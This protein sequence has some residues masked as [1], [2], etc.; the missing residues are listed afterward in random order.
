MGNER[1]YLAGFEIERMHT[2]AVAGVRRNVNRAIVAGNRQG[3]GLSFERIL[4]GRPSAVGTFPVGRAQLEVII[5]ADG[6]TN[7]LLI[8]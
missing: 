7:V 5:P 1:L 8:E 3:N 2:H 6:E 4:E